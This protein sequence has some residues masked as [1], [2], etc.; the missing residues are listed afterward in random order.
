MLPTPEEPNLSTCFDAPNIFA[1]E[2]W[3]RLPLSF[4]A[5]CKLAQT[6]M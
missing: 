3:T 4:N 5:L 1:E 2:V 6:A